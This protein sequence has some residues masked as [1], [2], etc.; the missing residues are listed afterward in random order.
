MLMFCVLLTLLS[1]FFASRLGIRT[2]LAEMVPRDIPQVK[3]YFDITEGYSSDAAVMITLES[4]DKNI[5]LMQE[6]AEEIAAQLENIVLVRPSKNAKLTL[7]QRHALFKGEFPQGVKYDTLKL[8]RRIDYKH[9]EEFLSRYGLLIK[10]PEE[11]E[12]IAAVVGSPQIQQILANVNFEFEKIL[13]RS[14][15][16]ISHYERSEL[17]R[18]INRIQM[19]LESLERF[20]E[21]GDSADVARQIS[22]FLKG[23]QYHISSDNTTLLMT[24]QSAVSFDQFDE[25]MYL[26]YRI[27]DTLRVMRERYSEL[28]IGRSG[29]IMLQV[30]SVNGAAMNFGWST[31]IDFAIIF[32]IL[33][34]SF[35]EWK[36]PLFL[37][38]ALLAGIIWTAGV[39]GL[40]FGEINI[41]SAAFCIVLVGL[42]VDYGIHFISGFSD[43]RYVD[44]S[45]ARSIAYMYSRVGSGVIIGA[46]T[47]AAVFF[48]LSL[49]GF[50]A[51]LQM[52]IVIGISV[53]V[54]LTAQILILPALIS[55]DNKAYSIF[56]PALYRCKLG[57]IVKIYHMIETVISKVFKVG[58]LL[59]FIRREEFWFLIH[60]GKQISRIP[61]AVT[62]IAV[63]IILVVLCAV[64]ASNMEWEYDFMAI[65]PKNA[66]STVT[67]NTILDKFEMF[68]SFVMVEARSIEECRELS[69]KYTEAGKKTG[70]IG[71]VDAITEFL[72]TREVWHKNS[73]VLEKLRE[74]L[75]SESGDGVI[76]EVNVDKVAAEL[77][78][79]RQNV[80]DLGKAFTVSENSGDIM[81]VKHGSTPV[82][83]DSDNMI[84][85]LAA[86]VRTASQYDSEALNN[87]QEIVYSTLKSNLDKMTD[88]PILTL[89][90]LPDEILGR[91]MNSHNNNVLINV[92]PR[93]YIWDE[94]SL[95]AF[96]TEVESIS[97]RTTGFLFV[98]Q[99]LIELMKEKGWIAIILGTI[100]TILILLI[101]LRS[102]GHAALA[103]LSLV[104][105]MV[106]MFGI[107]EVLGMKFSIMTFMALPLIIGIGLDHGI[108]VADRYMIEGRGSVP[109]V[110]K[111]TGRAVLLTSVVTMMGFGSLG[112]GEHVGLADFGKTIFFGIGACFVSSTFVLPAVITVWEFFKY[113]RPAS[114]VNCD[115]M[116]S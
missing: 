68:P 42:G 109:L 52:G 104:V 32:I 50:Q 88:A 33:I 115:R 99:F 67:Q 108:H 76:D 51:Y 37:F 44:K 100:A 46:L 20:I 43:G 77:H 69:R 27:D 22:D 18:E 73:A 114:R 17:N 40:L 36:N 105:G 102:P 98:V 4:A 47:T 16:A 38:V 58:F 31:F 30:D 87:F 83:S 85:R 101:E 79:L 106:W 15:R 103:I 39:L 111:S 7:K 63:T 72:P 74:D 49:I 45:A 65:Q 62:V 57:F 82:N 96:T 78:R 92:Y 56:A 21:N 95:R 86:K 91:Y 71:R 61:V 9:N 13:A 48:C 19:L 54:M 1:A 24:L 35:K 53:I 81:F 94:K 64:R 6:A 89:E 12:R 2:Q 90:N 11:L 5:R 113:D 8:V 75:F 28:T 59:K 112:L 116:D 84:A 14:E 41:L 70:L 110:L 97:E 93:G 66:L 60:L 29:T 80:V 26:G 107:M 23:S 55:F 3:E 10:E 25:M 34:G